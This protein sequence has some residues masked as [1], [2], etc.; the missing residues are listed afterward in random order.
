M[1]GSWKKSS[2]EGVEDLL[3]HLGA[4]NHAEKAKESDLTTNITI[5]GNKF[6]IERS[7]AK[8]SYSNT[9]EAGSETEFNTLKEGFKPKCST[10][11]EG[12]K[13]TIKSN[14]NDY[15]HVMELDGGKLKETFT[16]KGQ[17]ATRWSEKA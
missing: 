8:G 1:N 7:R 3:K 9:F 12:G 6:T 4:E 15:E 17:S 5:D 14:N 2:S 13:L 16:V 11:Y 10:S